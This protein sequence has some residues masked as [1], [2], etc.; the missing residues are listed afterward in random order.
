MTEPDP[1][2]VAF[3]CKYCGWSEDSSAEQQCSSSDRAF[4]TPC[5]GLPDDPGM[6][7]AGA[8]WLAYRGP[9]EALTEKLTDAGHKV[10]WT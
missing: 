6:V 2:D 1:Y 3:Y 10:K 5:P 8:R 4:H 7:G 9:L